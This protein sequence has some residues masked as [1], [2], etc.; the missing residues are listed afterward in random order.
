MLEKIIDS[1]RERGEREGDGKGKR[2]CIKMRRIVGI[3]GKK[4]K[5]RRRKKRNEAGRRRKIKGVE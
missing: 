4:G 2:E 3:G 1:R 5:R